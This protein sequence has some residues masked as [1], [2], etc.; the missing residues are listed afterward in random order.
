MSVEISPLE[1]RLHFL[2][3]IPRPFEKCGFTVPSILQPLL[4]TS[5]HTL[6]FRAPCSSEPWQ[7]VKGC[8]HGGRNCSWLWSSLLTQPPAK[9]GG[10]PPPGLIYR[11]CPA[12]GRMRLGKGGQSGAADLLELIWAWGSSGFWQS[13]PAGRVGASS[14]VLPRTALF[15]VIAGCGGRVG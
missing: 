2:L 5:T 11:R 12:P 15:A 10:Q 3:P 1:Y 13:V 14:T 9:D 8:V 6:R 7:A 4:N